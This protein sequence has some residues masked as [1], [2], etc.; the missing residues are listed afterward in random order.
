MYT[1]SM[2]DKDNIERLPALT[3][4]EMHVISWIEERWQRDREFPTI[5]DFKSSWGKTVKMSSFL[6]NPVVQLALRNRGIKAPKSENEVPNAL[7]QEQLAAILVVLDYT[8]KRSMATKLRQ[9]GLNSTKWNGWMR[10]PVFKEYLQS[11]SADN[12]KDALY[13][14]QTS[15]VKSVESGDVNAIKY[16][17]G[18]TG[19]D[20]A[21]TQT[22]ENFRIIISKLMEA[23]TVRINDDMLL[24]QISDDFSKILSGGSV[25]VAAVQHQVVS[26]RLIEESI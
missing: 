24:R 21:N 2:T 15:L 26:Q 23:L 25:D 1:H 13:V 19:A 14:A 20:G 10:N 12:F 17:M 6:M 11:I 18:V 4:H 22:L 3:S 16:Y 5:Q 7:S 8:D 9:M